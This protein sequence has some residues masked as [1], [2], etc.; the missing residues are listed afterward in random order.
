MGSLWQLDPDGEWPEQADGII[1]LLI[2][3]LAAAA[4]RPGGR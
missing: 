4:P 3:G 2:I 1:D